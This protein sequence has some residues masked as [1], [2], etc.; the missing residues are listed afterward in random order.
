MCALFEN[1][2]NEEKKS[3]LKR[4]QAELFAKLS[5]ECI[6]QPGYTLVHTFEYMM[7]QLT[8][9]K[10]FTNSACLAP[11]PARTGCLP[12]VCACLWN[13][14]AQIHLKRFKEQF[15]GLLLCNHNQNVWP[16]G[17]SKYYTPTILHTHYNVNVLQCSCN[18]IHTSCTLTRTHTLTLSLFLT[19]LPACLLLWH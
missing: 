1:K 11:H 12:Y 18:T 3:K 15:L 13:L 4:N 19:H 5:W 2:K 9:T 17:K 16:E 6:V 10:Q 7:Q 8:T 14:C